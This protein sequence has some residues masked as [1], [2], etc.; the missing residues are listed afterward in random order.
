[1]A[2]IVYSD[3]YNNTIKSTYKSPS[4][5]YFQNDN[6]KFDSYGVFFDNSTSGTQKPGSINIQPR[7]S[8]TYSG[9]YIHGTPMTIYNLSKDKIKEQ[10]T[11]NYC[12][13]DRKN[14]LLNFNAIKELELF[15]PLLNNEIKSYNYLLNNNN[16]ASMKN[17]IK[18]IH[19]SISKREN[20]YDETTVLKYM[21]TKISH[22]EQNDKN[23]KFYNMSEYEKSS[24][25]SFIKKRRKNIS[26]IPDE[27]KTL[28]NNMKDLENELKECVDNF[29]EYYNDPDTKTKKIPDGNI[30]PKSYPP[31]DNEI[32]GNN[33]DSCR[34]SQTYHSP[35][36][37]LLSEKQNRPVYGT[38]RAFDIVGPRSFKYPKNVNEQ[39]PFNTLYS[40]YEVQEKDKPYNKKISETF[41][42][43]DRNR[44]FSNL[45]DKSTGLYSTV[46]DNLTNKQKHIYNFLK[47][48]Y[49]KV[50]VT[51][52]NEEIVELS[53]QGVKD[54]LE[55]LYNN[56]QQEFNEDPRSICNSVNCVYDVQNYKTTK[57]TYNVKCGSKS[58]LGT[59]AHKMEKNPQTSEFVRNN[60]IGNN[61]DNINKSSFYFRNKATFNNPNMIDSN[62]TLNSLKSQSQSNYISNTN[63]LRDEVRDNYFK[64]QTHKI[65][66]NL[67]Y[68]G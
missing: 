14:L 64:Q 38:K 60:I 36:V 68:R 17:M 47:M 1:M 25:Q 50:G 42:I 46:P 66:N 13:T 34:D 61:F 9:D 3:K 19:E 24:I 51:K 26:T 23:T 20:V 65:R 49:K 27:I 43:K 59:I 41:A 30:L 67:L 8:I 7:P 28:R 45:D 55:N 33:F 6:Q 12:N 15:V 54:G 52:S 48:F 63:N 44:L 32:F 57:D 5:K 31:K 18:Q 56:L 2:N 11:Y 16:L 40:G 29:Y 10:I 35:T 62:L 39:L 53:K 4:E 58:T 37:P 21:S 22:I